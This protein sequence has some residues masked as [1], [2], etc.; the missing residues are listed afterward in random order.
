MAHLWFKG[1]AE[2]IIQYRWITIFI[3]VLCSIFLGSNLM[4][5]QIDMDQDTWV[6][7]DHPY[8]KSTKVIDRV[9]GGRNVLI[10]SVVPKSGDIY[11]TKI[12][13]KIQQIQSDIESLPEAIKHNILSIAAKKVKD[14]RGSD[15]GLVVKRVLETIPQ[16]DAEMAALKQRVNNNPIYINSLVSPDGKA[17]AIIADFKIDTSK[18][19][20]QIVKDKIDTIIN[21]QLDSSVNI[22][23][24]GLPIDFAWFEKHMMKMPLFFG[25][26][27]LIIM[28]IQYLS[29]R[30]FQGMILPI[31]TAILS[32]FWSLGFMGLIGV[33]MDGMNTTTPILIMSVAAGHAIQI[34]KRY[35]EEYNRVSQDQAQLPAKKINQLAIVNSIAHVGPVMFVAGLIASISFYTLATYDVSVV[36]H[37]GVFAGSGIM[38]TLI[39]E[40]TFIPAL[41]AIL[42][43]PKTKEINS[44]KQKG[45]L[46][47]QLLSTANKLSGPKAPRIL[48]ISLLAV[49]VIASGSYFIEADNS[50]KNYSTHDSEV[51]VHDRAI[52]QRFG[53]TNTIYFLIEGKKKD[54]IKDPRVLNTISKLQAYL[55]SQPEVGKTQSIADMVKRLNQAM[56]NEKVNHNSIPDE[57]SL[58]A[59]Y[60]FMYTL[61]GSP[62]DFDSYVNNDYSSAVVWTF[63][64]TDS[65][66][67][68]K[69]LGQAVSERFASQL[70]KGVTLRMGGSLPQTIAG[71][72]SLTYGKIKNVGQMALVVFIL[73][74]LILRSLVGGLFVT[75]PLIIVVSTNFGVMGWLGVPLDM[76]TMT[77]AAMAIGIGADYELYLLFRFREEI[78]RTGNL[79]QATRNSL[80][81][82]GKAVIYV[83]LSI[84]AGYACLLLSGFA[85][86]SRLAIM[87]IATMIAS[88]FVAIVFLRAMTATFKPRFM[89]KDTNQ[90]ITQM[91][92]KPAGEVNVQQ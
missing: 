9:F 92:L 81:T 62:Q 51:R 43:P 8:V 32:V 56:H 37:F 79:Q 47:R 44:E 89:F 45:W 40:M 4:N 13:R 71:N 72:D 26:A 76:G 54:T 58:V 35:Y 38:A 53:G 82:S 90:A 68:A 65:T 46:D 10:I 22:Y 50:L 36:K 84:A 57:Q 21:R 91:S 5:L 31:V 3:V 61:S 6:P 83:A 29:F 86:Y 52:N 88:A 24:A 28:L 87:V 66:Q 34:L 27:I 18:P 15:E 69:T 16:T 49:L 14:I 42:P 11:Q 39:L 48:G 23:T 59:Q 78:Q 64:K 30:S 60:L 33:H 2:K 67:Y 7:Q 75:L 17:A 73:S 41:R 80:T 12:L 85:F 63:L 1:F 55:E 20:Y 19:S 25:S 74:S 70:P 77:T